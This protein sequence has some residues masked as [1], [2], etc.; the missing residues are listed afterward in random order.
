[1]FLFFLEQ[2]KIQFPPFLPPLL[3]H[4]TLKGME[5]EHSFLTSSFYSTGLVEEEKEWS[6]REWESKN[7][8]PNDPG[9]HSHMT[10]FNAHRGPHFGFA[11]MP[12][13]KMCLCVF[14]VTFLNTRY[15]QVRT[16]ELHPLSTAFP[17][18]CPVCNSDTR[19]MNK[20]KP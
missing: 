14:G 12:S 20:S 11:Y 15:A 1:M 13:L 17:P 18:T 7:G 8:K 9:A 5:T 16:A 6:R 10:T 3:S 4:R 2:Q 19:Q